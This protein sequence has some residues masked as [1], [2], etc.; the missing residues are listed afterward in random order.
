MPK[1]THIGWRMELDPDW[2]DMP[3]V[4]T[5]GSDAAHTTRPLNPHRH[6]GFEITYAE[7]GKI[8]W[9]LEK[10]QPFCFGGGDISLVQP[11]VLHEGESRILQPA[12]IHWLILN[13]LVEN[14]EKNTPFRRN[15]IL[16][17]HKKLTA[18]GNSSAQAG[19]LLPELFRLFRKCMESHHRKD[20]DPLLLSQSQMLAAQI[21]IETI[22][23]FE[24]NS[25]KAESGPVRYAIDLMN[26]RLEDKLSIPEI[27][28]KVGLGASRFYSLFKKKMG[29]SPAD[30]LQQLRCARAR[31]YLTNTDESITNIA[32][33]LGFSSSQYFAD[34][35]R[36][37]IGRTPSEFRKSD[38]A[39][40]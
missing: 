24:A 35:F 9:V 23:A 10:D 14:A 6:A 39:S 21:V 25:P 30:Y 28:S 33:R 16:H 38:K 40:G 12:A 1:K 37:Y 2:L 11:Q 36:K 32:F 4:L 22:R 29:Q 20:Q 15:Q 3:M 19:N 8:H 26:S 7:D 18:F 31:E 17:I 34:C 27:A 13:P 5:G